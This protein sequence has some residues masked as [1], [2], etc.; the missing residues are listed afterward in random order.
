MEI[1]CRM[2][3]QNVIYSSNLLR[4]NELT[5]RHNDKVNTLNVL[6]NTKYLARI[7]LFNEKL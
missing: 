3:H 6:L 5:H 4:Y 1:Q 2:S 7:L